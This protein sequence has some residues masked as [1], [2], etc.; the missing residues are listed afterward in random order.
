MPGARKSRFTREGQAHRRRYGTRPEGTRPTLPI[1]VVV[2]DDARTAPGYFGELKREVKQHVTVR[3]LP[4]T[5]ADATP[6]RVVEEAIRRKEELRADRDAADKDAVWVLLDIEGDARQRQQAEDAASKAEKLDVSVA[7]S[8]PCFEVWTL[9]HFEDTGTR[10]DTCRDALARVKRLWKRE[11]GQHL[12]HKAQADYSKII[13]RRAEA[14]ERAERHWNQGDP[15]RTAVYQVVR[16]I[17]QYL[18]NHE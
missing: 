11:F 8:V 18:P 2:C 12:G 15:S 13:G 1:V 10:F 7:R 16:N 14:A 5:C 4:A 6:D 17:D 3:V 9:L